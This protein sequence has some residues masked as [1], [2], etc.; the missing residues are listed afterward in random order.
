MFSESPFHA[1]KV[2][3][4]TAAAGVAHG[5]FYTHFGSKLTIFVAVVDEVTAEGYVRTSIRRDLGPEVAPRIQIE[6]ANRRYFDFYRRNARILASME[7][8]A[9]D[10]P[11]VE[12]LRQQIFDAYSYRTAAAIR[13][14]R[15]GRRPAVGPSDEIL[16]FCLGAMVERLAQL[17]FVCGVTS[18]TE[19]EALAALTGSWVAVLGLADAP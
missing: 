17:L 8:L 19:D 14:W 10:H 7:D 15:R 6:A 16:A 1:V 18:P 5:S 4:I 12:A 13:R 9:P 11:V 3:D 2:A